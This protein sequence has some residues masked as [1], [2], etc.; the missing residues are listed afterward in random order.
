M[1]QRLSDKSRM[2]DV[3]SPSQAS[4]W[5]FIPRESAS[6]CGRPLGPKSLQTFG[7]VQWPLWSR[8][9]GLILTEV[10]SRRLDIFLGRRLGTKGRNRIRV[11]GPPQNI[12]RNIILPSHGITLFRAQC[13]SFGPGR[14]FRRDR[15]LA[16]HHP[17]TIKRANNGAPI[18]T[19]IHSLAPWAFR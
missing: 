17:S 14:V 16:G 10:I 5:E 7:R 15:K 6:S 11:D 4:T 8:E 3:C 1:V 12:S 2:P 18:K 19:R 9:T 13:H